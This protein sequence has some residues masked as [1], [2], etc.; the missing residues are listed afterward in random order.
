MRNKKNKYRQNTFEEKQVERLA[1]SAV[2]I[3]DK[4]T[5]RKSVV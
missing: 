4:A 2:K 1:V 5:D 3:Y